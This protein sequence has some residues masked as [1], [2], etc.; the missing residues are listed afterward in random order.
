M[1]IALKLK[2]EDWVVAKEGSREA[3]ETAVRQYA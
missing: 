2:L 1:C 3:T